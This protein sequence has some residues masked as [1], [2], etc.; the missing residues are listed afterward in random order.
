VDGPPRVDIMANMIRPP[1]AI[2]AAMIVS[3]RRL[4]PA[5]RAGAVATGDETF[6]VA[7]GAGTSAGDG[8]AAATVGAVH[9][10][11]TCEGDGDDCAEAAALWWFAHRSHPSHTVAD[12]AISI[13]HDAQ[14]FTRV[15]PDKTRAH[16]RGV[17]DP[18]KPCT[19]RN[20]AI[21]RAPGITCSRRNWHSTDK[22]VMELEAHAGIRGPGSVVR[23]PGCGI[24]A[25]GS[26]SR[27]DAESVVRSGDH[28]RIVAMSAYV[29]V[30]TP[31]GPTRGAELCSVR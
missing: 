26:G 21:K 4:K 30:P 15:A 11:S 27:P 12:S 29:I 3:S 16:T 6:G 2:A 9:G 22:S 20:E 13:P 28:L 10:V 14:R 18:R 5:F 25:A 24:R 23:D 1:T 17:Q 31:C 19:R 7:A 8:G